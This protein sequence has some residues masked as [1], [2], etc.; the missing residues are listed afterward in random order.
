MKLNKKYIIVIVILVLLISLPNLVDAQCAM[1]QANVK[2]AMQNEKGNAIGTGLNNG[3][4]FLLASPYVLIGTALI[5]WRK[6][7]K[8][9]NLAIHESN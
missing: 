9:Q 7:S 1:C 4:L 3:I 5:I 8:K 6:K 2:T